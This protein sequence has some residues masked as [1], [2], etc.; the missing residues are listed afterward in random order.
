MPVLRS[1][2]G[3]SEPDDPQV[4]ARSRRRVQLPQTVK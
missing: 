4:G 2:A 1:V 3:A